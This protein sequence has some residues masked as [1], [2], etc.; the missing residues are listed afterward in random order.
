MNEALI[1][2]KLDNI[3]AE[4]STLKSEIQAMKTS[5]RPTTVAA[6]EHCSDPGLLPPTARKYDAGDFSRLMENL[7][8]NVN[9][10]HTLLCQS[11]AGD[12]LVRDV[13]PVTQQAYPHIVKFFA[14]LE[15]QFSVDELTGLMRNLTTNINSLNEGI[16]ML[17]MAVELKDEIVP[18]AQIGY[19]KVI[20]FLN[21]LH[22]GEFQ[23]EQLGT[24][25][26]T[27]L[28]NIHTFSDL[29][30]MIKPM[31]ELIKDLN[32][33][34]RETDVIANTNIWLDSL[35]Q[36][37]GMMKLA[38]TAFANMK[39]FKITDQQVDEISKAIGQIDFAHIKPITPFG[40]V[41]SLMNPK[42]Q[43]ALG[44]LFMILQTTG[45]C[46]QAYQQNHTRQ[47]I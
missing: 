36:S 3:S 28:M 46:L 7:N 32:V 34:L 8:T 25:L 9:A 45:A 6:L 16:N 13:G 1:L 37:S 31:T 29:M 47:T 44:A 38:G 10:I 19:P 24:L 18:V 33:L 12:E 41:K 30:N 40:A 35:Q 2:E 15:D 11:K 14:E 17:R 39:Q 42:V 43:E 26:H 23:S 21:T 20:K 5:D 4:I 27:L 22:E